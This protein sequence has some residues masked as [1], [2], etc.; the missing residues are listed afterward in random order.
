MNSTLKHPSHLSAKKTEDC[1]GEEVQACKTD[2]FLVQSYSALRVQPSHLVRLQI[3]ICWRSKQK[4][5]SPAKNVIPDACP[6]EIY[7]KIS[8]ATSDTHEAVILHLGILVILASMSRPDPINPVNLPYGARAGHKAVQCAGKKS[9][10]RGGEKR[11][12]L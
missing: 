4:T 1:S 9:N 3:L 6:T 5:F 8:I 11:N 2:I 10:E 7:M 12:R